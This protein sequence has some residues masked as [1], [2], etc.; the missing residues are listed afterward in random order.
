VV[1]VSED[2]NVFFS[3]V[4]AAVVGDADEAKDKGREAIREFPDGK[5]AAVTRKG[6]PKSSQPTPLYLRPYVAAGT[7]WVGDPRG[8]VGHLSGHVEIAGIDY[9]IAYW[10]GRYHGFIGPDE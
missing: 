3:F 5:L 7:I 4:H 10:L 6:E 1:P 8:V 9:L 2:H